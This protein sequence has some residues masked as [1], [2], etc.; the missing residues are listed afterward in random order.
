ML[1]TLATWISDWSFVAPILTYLLAVSRGN[2]RK[3]A[4]S[5]GAVFLLNFYLKIS[6]NMELSG[7]A[8][9]YAAVPAALSGMGILAA[10]VVTLFL[11]NGERIKRGKTFSKWFFYFFYPGHLFVLY[12][13]EISLHKI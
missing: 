12:L 2:R 9:L 7:G 4:L 10:A 1:L 6:Y 3:M 13:L 8:G 11:Y 5:Y